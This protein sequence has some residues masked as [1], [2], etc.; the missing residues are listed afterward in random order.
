[1]QLMVHGAR[2][3][4]VINIDQ[5]HKIYWSNDIYVLFE[6]ILCLCATVCVYM[7]PQFRGVSLVI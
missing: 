6:V 7:F 1:M 4:K 3:A 5:W 2:L